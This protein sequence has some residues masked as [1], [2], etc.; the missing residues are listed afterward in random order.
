MKERQDVS[1]LAERIRRQLPAGQVTE[2]R[3][4]GGTTFS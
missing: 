4:V 3:M 2:K 1:M